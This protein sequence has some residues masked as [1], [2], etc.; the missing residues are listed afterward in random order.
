MVPATVQRFDQSYLGTRKEGEVD[1]IAWF[2]DHLKVKATKDSL[3]IRSRNGDEIRLW[4]GNPSYQNTP[5]SFASVE[6][7]IN[8]IEQLGNVEN[9]IVIQLFNQ[10]E[11]MDERVVYTKPGTVRMISTMNPTEKSSQLPSNMVEI[12][13]TLFYMKLEQAGSFIPY[14]EYDTGYISI[15]GFYMDKYPVTNNEFYNFIEST[16]YSPKDPTNFLKHWENGKYPRD[17]K[18]KPV[19][20][21]SYED[22]LAYATWAGK[23]LP[24]EV[25][26]QYAAQGRDLR[27]Y[28][29][30]NT[31]D[32]T[33]CNT[34]NDQLTVVNEY[35]GGASPFGVIDMVGNVWQI[36]NDVYDN[37]SYRFIIIRG[38]SFYNP[39]S[40]DWYVQGGPQALNRSQMLLRVSP[41]FER[42]ATVG[43]RCAM[44]K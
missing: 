43:F 44:D 24:S 40:S 28:P 21:I 14:P 19:V 22:A 18:N 37:G 20:Y 17:A 16:G 32:S 38:G 2:P 10:G 29:W 31:F 30:G 4:S 33:L 5:V 39:T 3:Y 9:K 15:Q 6:Q 7:N 8:I 13:S 35:P 26:W 42:N 27:Q 12:P 11:L 23:R 25:E 41:G 34:G 36:T 1:C